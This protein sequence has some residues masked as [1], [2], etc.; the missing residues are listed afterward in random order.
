MMAFILKFKKELAAIAGFLV[1]FG[2]IQFQSL[3]IDALSAKLD[4]A[5]TKLDTEKLQHKACQSSINNQNVQIDLLLLEAKKQVILVAE[6]KD[7]AEKIKIK[8]EGDIEKIKNLPSIKS[9]D[10]GMDKLWL[11]FYK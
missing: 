8:Y 1:L 10:E 11:N 3:K 9:C 6:A 2:T 7:K 4:A 5:N